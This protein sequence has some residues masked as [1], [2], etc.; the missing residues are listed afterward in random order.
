M[1]NPKRST[2]KAKFNHLKNEKSPY[3][4]Q[5]AKNP[6]NWYPWG[7]EAFNKAK[8][9]DKPIFLSIGY[10]TCHWCHVMEK[11]SFEDHEVSE[12]L[13]KVFIAVKVDREERP[14]IDGIFMT[15]SQIMTGTGGWP[16]TIIMTPDK[17]PF[18]AG[19]YFPKESGFGTIGIKD[20]ILNV[21]D[22]W[23]DNREEALK[24][25]DQILKALKDVS[26]TE[27]GT[28]LGMEILEKTYNELSKV[29]DEE[30]G[31]FGEFQKFPTPHNL[32]F[33]L[34]YF[35][36]QGNKH[37]LEMV[38]KTLDSMRMGGI[39][40]QLGFGFHR[41]SVDRFWLVPH[42]EKMLYDQALIAMAYTEA[43]Q[44]TG[45]VKYKKTADQIFTYVIRDMKSPE[46]GFFSAEDADSEG[47]E[48]KYYMW[49]DD[50]IKGA[51]EPEE[52]KLASMLY[53][54]NSS[55]NFNDGYSHNTNKNILHLNQTYDRLAENLGVDPE[56]IEDKIENIRNKLYI[57]REKRIR[58][59]KDD[60]I[61]TDWNGL[62]IAS[63]A[64]AGQVFNNDDYNGYA[65]KAADFIL[66][67]LTEDGR[68]MH[69][70]RENEASVTGNLD[71]YSFLIWGLLELYT[72]IFDVKYLNAAIDL[73][74]VLM[75]HFWDGENYGFYFTSDDA[76]EVLIREKKTY[77]S[78][79]PSG[80]SVELLNLIKIARYTEDPEL[81]SMVNKMI[82]AF[83]EDVKRIPA[84]HTQFIAGVDFKLGPSFE[85]VVVGN[86][87]SKD[88]IQMIQ[89]LNQKYIPNKVIMLKDPEKSGEINGI[90][91]S[92]KLKKSIEDKATAYVC[93]AGSCKIPTNDIHEMLSLM[94]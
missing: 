81:E 65:A 45:D 11:E 14:D 23:N 4:I 25:G 60:K 57:E 71:D 7:D 13:N 56:E 19:T 39:F 61:L 64:K 10:S 66:D 32:I 49:T 12:L 9:E 67:N 26:T 52:V 51:L 30:N 24:S 47:V 80:N 63:L 88:T 82:T 31:G 36:R 69:R 21:Q 35:K 41:Y 6:V 42:F 85:V 59:N 73:N 54:I 3:L 38:K 79:T 58:P 20:L 1:E 90:N 72:A 43:F 70:Y 83:S 29:Y 37:A 77:D 40:D 86:P 78:A 15:A 89:S 74:K 22:I 48:G 68:L 76:E 27:T 2:S 16:L 91:P 34:R 94:K 53:S 46:G 62:M 55:G 28:D 44:V 50:E 92:I 18:F 8:I 5:H 87:E 75:E 33:L 84:G 93:T 17:K